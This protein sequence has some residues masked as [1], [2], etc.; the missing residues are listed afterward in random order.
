MG[1]DIFAY[2]KANQEVAYARFSMFNDN[3]YILYDLLQAREFHAGVSGSGVCVEFSDVMMN[4]VMQDCNLLF[5]KNDRAN[6]RDIDVKQI[7]GFIKNSY[8]AA[9]NEGSVK[10]CFG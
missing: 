2:N 4:Q 7:Q 1:H 10:I 8:E 5:P 6:R 9:K 3:S